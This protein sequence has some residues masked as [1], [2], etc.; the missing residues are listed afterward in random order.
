MCLFIFAEE[1]PENISL[2]A[3]QMSE[4]A[5]TDVKSQTGAKS[6]DETESEKTSVSRET[7]MSFEDFC[8]CFQ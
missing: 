1:L 5:D 3:K 2:D 7:W 6:K 8:V 4:T